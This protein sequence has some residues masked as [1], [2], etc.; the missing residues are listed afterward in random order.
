[1]TSPY[2]VCKAWRARVIGDETLSDDAHHADYAGE[3]SAIFATGRTN[4]QISELMWGADGGLASGGLWAA[5]QLSTPNA[6]AVSG[7]PKRS[8][9]ATLCGSMTFFVHRSNRTERLVDALASVVA[10]PQ[11]NVLAPEW[12]V[13]SSPGMERW[14]SMQLAKRVGVWANPSFPFPRKLIDTIMQR[15]LG[16][17]PA[18]A[19]GYEPTCMLFSIAALLSAARDDERFAEVQRYLGDDERP[20]RRLALATRLAELFDQYLTYRPERVQQWAAGAEQD[21]QAPLL[22]A[23]ISKHGSQH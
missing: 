20:S 15:A 19:S 9:R 22:R 1:V 21:F 11:A 12:I 13:V 18:A 5:S 4:L 10:A 3:A 8:A 6:Y 7:A 17:V 14:L 16:D 2:A 23:L